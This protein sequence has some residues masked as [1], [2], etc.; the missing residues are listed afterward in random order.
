MELP[1]VHF[2]PVSCHS[3]FVNPNILLSTL[4]SNTLTLTPQSSLNVRDFFTLRPVSHCKVRSFEH[5]SVCELIQ[6]L[7]Y[8]CIYKSD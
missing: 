6:S 1:T 8:A 2:S 7:K 3:C 4:F 5:N